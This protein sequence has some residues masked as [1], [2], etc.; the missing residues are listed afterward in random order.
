MRRLHRHHGRKGGPR[1]PDP[2]RAAGGLP[3]S[4]D[5]RAGGVEAD[6]GTV[7]TIEGI[8]TPYHL[9][10]LQQAFIDAGAIQCGYCTPGMIMSTKA[11]LMQNPH[12]SEEEIRL[13]LSGNICRCSGYVQIVR[14]VQKAARKLEERSCNA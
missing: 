1:L 3:Y 13:T 11:L 6:G 4:Y 9:H 12:P 7:E 5:R 10:P 8:G 14:A 2:R